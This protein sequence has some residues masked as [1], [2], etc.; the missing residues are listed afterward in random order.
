MSRDSLVLIT[1]GAGFIGS[2]VADQLL[3]HGYRVRV[4]DTLDPQVHGE[5]R[6]LFPRYLSPE[7]ETL[8]GDVRSMRDMERA[9][10]GVEA[11]FHFAAAVGVGQS[12]YQIERYTDVNNRGTAVLL[13]ALRISMIFN[14]TGVILAEMYAS[15]DGIGHQIETWGEN[16]QMPQLL[17]GV[18]LIAVIAMTFNELVRWVETRCS[19]WRT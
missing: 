9:L 3:E 5:S 7:I 4:L 12:M 18:L 16:F 17:A 11:V 8:R 15:R 19:H 6:A 14:L 2:H 1:G 13:E 10:Q